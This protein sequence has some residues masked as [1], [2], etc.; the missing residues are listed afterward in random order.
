[1]RRRPPGP[2]VPSKA[3]VDAERWRVARHEAAHAVVA[4]LCGHPF[5]VTID[6]TA[7]GFPRTKADG[8]CQLLG[9]IPLEDQLLVSMAGRVVDGD[10]MGAWSD[11]ATAVDLAH[12]T[13]PADV[14]GEL[15]SYDMGAINIIGLPR[16]AAAIDALAGELVDR[17]TLEP[18]EAE[19]AILS[20]LAKPVRRRRAG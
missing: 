16:V 19:Q 4:W 3:R 15:R 20:A 18:A 12:A 7:P 13:N 1:M 6:P 14:A 11:I 8:H 5:R 17:G 9:R 10:T 2:T